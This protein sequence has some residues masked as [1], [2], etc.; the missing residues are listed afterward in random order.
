MTKLFNIKFTLSLSAVG[1]FE[2]TYNVFF[3]AESEDQARGRFLTEINKENILFIDGFMWPMYYTRAII[4]GCTSVST[5]IAPGSLP[6]RPTEALPIPANWAS[7][8]P[9][10]KKERK[11]RAS[12]PKAEPVGIKPKGRRR[13]KKA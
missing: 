5:K 7:A 12:K 6:T 4:T 11:K 8:S 3:A 9:P 2:Q 1:D 10:V 13:S